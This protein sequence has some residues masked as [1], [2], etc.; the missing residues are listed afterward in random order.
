MLDPKVTLFSYSASIPVT[1]KTENHALILKS[2]N[3][4]AFSADRIFSELD[5]L[6]FDTLNSND[7]S[8]GSLD[9]EFV[10][11]NGMI[12]EVYPDFYTKC[13]VIRTNTKCCIKPMKTKNAAHYSKVNQ[14]GD[15]V[16]GIRYYFK[17]S[18]EIQ[19]IK[20]C[21]ALLVEGFIALGDPR[22]VFGIMCQ[23]KKEQDIW[24]ISSSF[25]YRPK[26]AK[27]IKNLMD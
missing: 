9:I 19:Q 17:N 5:E 2:C 15:L 18:K 13:M 6:T 24:K 25:T 8:C 14:D 1:M 21:T 26:E 7:Y 16:I 27:N 10:I 23:L 3:V 4:Y 22:N 11:L 20:N 12:K